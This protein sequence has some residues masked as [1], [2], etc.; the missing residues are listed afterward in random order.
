M[1]PGTGRAEAAL[2]SCERWDLT[3]RPAGRPRLLAPLPGGHSNR[4]WLCAWGGRRLVLRLD[5]VAPAT[6]GLDRADEARSHA[7]AAA[8]GLAPALRFADAARGILV[9]DYLPPAAPAGDER[10]ALAGLLRAIHR[11]RAPA[12]ELQLAPY[13]TACEARAGI[14]AGDAGDRAR[15]LVAVLTAADPRPVLCH[16]D[17]NAANRL[18]HRGRL[19]AIDWEYAA[20]GNRWFDLAAAAA[21]RTQAQ[22]LLRA[23]AGAGAGRRER[24]AVD[25]AFALSRYIN[26]LWYTIQ[27]EPSAAAWTAATAAL[28]STHA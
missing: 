7:A 21:D 26:A 23:Y 19:W 22:A 13:L 14:E 17:L 28:E 9:C 20:R 27:G 18:W 15:R 16:H 25:A 2:A 4:S 11:L 3:P 5:A 1:A 6:P 10:V 24:H 8:A 12:R